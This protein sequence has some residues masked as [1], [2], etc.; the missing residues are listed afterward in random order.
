MIKKA[1]YVNEDVGIF[2]D[3]FDY[4]DFDDN[5]FLLLDL[6]DESITT[7]TEIC[8]KESSPKKVG[9]TVFSSFHARQEKSYWVVDSGFS[10][11]MIGEKSK[12]A[13]IKKYDGGL[14]SLE[15]ILVLRFVG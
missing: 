12:F 13:K 2:D 11:H 5:E 15:M 3:E 10:N 7:N 9:G 8:V 1:Y 14:I 6:K 4:G